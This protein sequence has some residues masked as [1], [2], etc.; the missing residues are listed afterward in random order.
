MGFICINTIC[1]LTMYNSDLQAIRTDLDTISV[2]RLHTFA[3]SLLAGYLFIH[4][5]TKIISIYMSV[6]R[7]IVLC[8]GAHKCQDNELLLEV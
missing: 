4:M 1:V 8:A 3:T 7:C 6:A 2:W 5:V